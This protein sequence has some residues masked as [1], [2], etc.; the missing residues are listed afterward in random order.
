M[1]S[2]LC[3]VPDCIYMVQSVD[4]FFVLHLRTIFRGTVEGD[5]DTSGFI[6]HYEQKSW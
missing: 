5:V 3:S 2:A 6:Y 1:G 4:I